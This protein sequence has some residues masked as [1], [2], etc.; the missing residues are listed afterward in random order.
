LTPLSGSL[1]EAEPL[2]LDLKRREATL[3]GET[4]DLTTGEFEILAYLMKNSGQTKTREEMLDDLKGVNFEA[5][6]RSMDVMVSRLRQK[7]QDDPKSPKFIKTIW[8]TGYL[9]L[10]KVEVRG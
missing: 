2:S 1:L 6:N 8:G 4:L 5:F 10:A 3:S 7:L 9:F